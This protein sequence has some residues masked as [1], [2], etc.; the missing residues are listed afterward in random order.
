MAFVVRWFGELLERRGLLTW[1]RRCSEAGL[2]TITNMWPNDE[3]PTYGPF[4]KRSVDG[5]GALGIDGDVLFIRGNQGFAAY[6]GAAVFVGMLRVAKNYALVHAH[7]GETGL[8]ARLYSGAPVVTSYLGSDLLAPQEGGSLLKL[9]RRVRS[10]MLR[11][12]ARLMTATTTK[13]QEMEAVLPARARRR[14]WVIPDGIDLERF[15][16]IDRGIARAHLGWSPD[17]RIVLF[18]G[19][20]NCAIKRP[21]LAEQAAG[22]ARADLPDLE[23][24][25]ASGVDPDEMPYH[26]CAADCLLHTS[27]SEGSPNV[28]KEALACNLPIVATPAGD[29]ERLVAGARPGG[30]LEADAGALAR[31]VIACCRT[32]IRSNGRSLTRDM[33]LETAAA[34]TLNLY[35]SLSDRFAILTRPMIGRRPRA[36][37]HEQPHLAAAAAPLE[38]G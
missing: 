15:K 38:S 8:V 26:Y 34:A 33:S 22:L 28:I 19:R 6:V 9:S 10:V 29:I 27:A 11:Q 20:P 23:L 21:W 31:E 2:L 17:S 1:E 7:G 25:I 13:T 4:I 32:P 3:D 30:V 24:V 35:Q 36:G 14:N 18:A 37:E 16:P 12:H 5:L